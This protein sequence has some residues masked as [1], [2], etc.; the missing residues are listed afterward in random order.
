MLNA[1]V[2]MTRAPNITAETADRR[3]LI[4]DC[5]DAIA[6]RSEGLEQADG[7]VLVAAEVKHDGFQFA[8]GA[9]CFARAEHVAEST[10]NRTETWAAL[11]ELNCQMVA[12]A[13]RANA[14]LIQ[15]R[16]GAHNVRQ[17]ATSRG[18]TKS[19]GSLPSHR[20]GSSRSGS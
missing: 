1:L 3:S 9:E 15:C 4:R 11:R 17:G 14:L 13:V 7:L 19:Y 6:R 18:S 12:E 20:F 8:L 5:N 10:T 2:R 16:G